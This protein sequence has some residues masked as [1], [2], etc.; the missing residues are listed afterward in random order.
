MPGILY[1]VLVVKFLVAC[2]WRLGVY[3]SLLPLAAPSMLTSA[4]GFRVPPTWS[5][6]FAYR[7]RF[8]AVIWT[9]AVHLAQLLS[10]RNGARRSCLCAS[11]VTCRST[12]SGALA[13]VGMALYFRAV[14]GSALWET[15]C[16]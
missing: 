16:V 13:A 12:V 1:A 7:G 15:L 3:T 8:F 11:I 9:N 5:A 14:L 4:I 6:G 2:G 10:L